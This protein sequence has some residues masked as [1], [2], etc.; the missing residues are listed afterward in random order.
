MASYPHEL[1]GGRRQRVMIAAAL[2][3]GP[4]LLLADEPTTA[5]DTVTQAEVLAVL[6]ELRQ[7]LGLA[8]LFIIHD[9]E[10]AAATCDRTAVLHAGSIVEIQRSADLHDRPR[11][12]YTARLVG[13]RLSMD[14]G[15]PHRPVAAPGPS[16]AGPI[17]E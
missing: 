4:R 5:L 11:H 7:R 10:L 15:P 17:L 3:A 2:T 16:P 8:M 6:G 13:A 1:S 14:A 9:L 12:P